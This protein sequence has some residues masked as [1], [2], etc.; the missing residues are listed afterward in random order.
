MLP[1]KCFAIHS[2]RS[3]EMTKTH[4]GQ[5]IDLY[6]VNSLFVKYSIVSSLLNIPKPHRRAA[7]RAERHCSDLTKDQHQISPY[8]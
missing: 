2:S 7:T 5:S 6:S 1:V 3:I 8:H 4:L